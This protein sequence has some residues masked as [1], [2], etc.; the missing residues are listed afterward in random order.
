MARSRHPRR[1]TAAP[2][3]LEI[4]SIDAG[5][6]GPALLALEANEPRLPAA[7]AAALL[8]RP[9]RAVVHIALR[10]LLERRL[11]GNLDRRPFTVSASGRPSLPDVPLD[12]NLSHCDGMALVA[13]GPGGPIG[14][15]IEPVDREL[16]TL[17]SRAG[18]IEAAARTL[19]SGRPLPG[20]GTSRLLAAWVR[21]EAFAKADGAGVAAL[22]S[23]LGIIG[24][25][26]SDADAAA[27]AAGVAAHSPKLVLEDLMVAG[28]FVAAVART[29]GTPIPVLR[30]FPCE[31]LALD[32]LAAQ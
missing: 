5:R 28:G 16:G 31:P 3:P 20:S 11:G 10:L 8:A 12:F 1:P 23:R 18:R 22:L 9:E 25:R 4:W 13:I 2:P 27:R 30:E 17:Q 7:H 21:I 19:A 15:D 6:C 32:A 24:T 14:V 29:D 26:I